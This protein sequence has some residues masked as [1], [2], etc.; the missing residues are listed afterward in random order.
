MQGALVP[1]IANKDRMDLVQHMFVVM[2]VFLLGF[3]LVTELLA[4]YFVYILAPGYTSDPYKTDIAISFIRITFPYI[5]TISLCAILSA[6]LNAN[7]KI[8]G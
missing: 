8:F 4:P 5:L 1:A 3:V 2:T 6:V 7:T